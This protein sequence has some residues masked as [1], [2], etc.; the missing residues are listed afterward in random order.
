[1]RANVE[2][3]RSQ[4][5]V[6]IASSGLLLSLTAGAGIASAQPDMGPVINTTCSYPQVVAALTAQDPA[7]ANRLTSS[8]FAAGIMQQFLN[9]G[10]GERASIAQQVQN[11]PG[12]AQYTGL[13]MQVAGTCN[14]F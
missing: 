13:I 1:M 5:K 8:P 11:S 10:P 4:T 6:F 2:F 3:M 9:A 14:N 7:A 12:A